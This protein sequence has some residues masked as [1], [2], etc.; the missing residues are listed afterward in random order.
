MVM[1]SGE[2]YKTHGDGKSEHCYTLYVM[3]LVVSACLYYFVLCV[4]M[5]VQCSL[6]LS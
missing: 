2:P 5:F 1:I 6:M 4:T 3:I